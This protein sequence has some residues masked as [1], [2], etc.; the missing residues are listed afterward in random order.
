[1]QNYFHSEVYC[2]SNSLLLSDAS[3]LLRLRLASIFGFTIWMPVM[4]FDLPLVLRQKSVYWIVSD[5]CLQL[6]LFLT[7]VGL[8]WQSRSCTVLFWKGF[9]KM[10]MKRNSRNMRPAKNAHTRET[11][12]QV[13]FPHRSR[14]HRVSST[15][16]YSITSLSLKWDTTCSPFENVKLYRPFH[17]NV[18]H[19]QTPSVLEANLFEPIFILIP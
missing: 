3:C 5:M 14:W 2:R 18:L 13:Y 1:M 17:F 16:T 15:R 12:G 19:Y 9:G 4:L 8:R 11:R 10:G 6:L 7:D